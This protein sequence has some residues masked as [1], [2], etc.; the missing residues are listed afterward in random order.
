[1]GCPLAHLMNSSGEA[2]DR[3]DVKW[4]SW[5][6]TFPAPLPP[7]EIV[8]ALL[9]PHENEKTSI[10]FSK[11]LAATSPSIPSSLRNAS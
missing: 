5:N 1:M 2:F 6:E 9:A 8:P 7:E 10:H 3:L 11:P 4:R